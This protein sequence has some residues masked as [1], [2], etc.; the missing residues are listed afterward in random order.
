[1][2]KGIMEDKAIDY[3]IEESRIEKLQHYFTDLSHDLKARKF[4][5]NF[6]DLAKE[7]GTELEIM[8]QFRR[9]RQQIKDFSRYFVSD[10]LC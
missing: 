7:T 10:Q 6:P 5:E 4:H 8:E 1:M 3:W 9:V 2:I